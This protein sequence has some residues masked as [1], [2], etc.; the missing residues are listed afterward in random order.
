MFFRLRS[1]NFLFLLLVVSSIFATTVFTS[2]CGKVKPLNL[3]SLVEEELS[4][5]QL[6]TQG[7]KQRSNGEFDAAEASFKEA[8]LKCEE[9]NGPEDA[10]TGTCVGYLAEL[11]KS[12][13]EW[14]KAEK[15]YKRWL[16]IMDQ[17]DKTGEQVKAIRD[18]YKVIKEKIFKYGLRKATPEE[19][20]EQEE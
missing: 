10:T 7:Q 18:G 5:E 2:S 9:K 19:Q 15:E 16:S 17:H 11:Y 20:A 3:S 14:L 8:I 6:V 12:Q 4:W 13:Q 1:I